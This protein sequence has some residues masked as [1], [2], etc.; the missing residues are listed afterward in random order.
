MAKPSLMAARLCNG[1][2]PFSPFVDQ[3]GLYKIRWQ[4][5]E[6]I[7]VCNAIFRLTI[8]CCSLKT[9]TI[10]LQNRTL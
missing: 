2:V 7:A 3:L 1:S 9:M 4:Y 10:K 6:D 8:S 5:Q